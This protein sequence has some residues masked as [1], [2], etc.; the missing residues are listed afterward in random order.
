MS[1]DEGSSTSRGV[2][3]TS[4]A[5]ASHPEM[6][7]SI[8]LLFVVHGEA[9]QVPRAKV[10][11]DTM[12]RDGASGVRENGGELTLSVVSEVLIGMTSSLLGRVR[13]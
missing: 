11:S 1:L 13:W 3:D 6:V 10:P 5:R 7:M 12:V 4:S 9:T 2:M 8:R